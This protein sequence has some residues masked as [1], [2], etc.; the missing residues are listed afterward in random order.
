MSHSE[1]NEGGLGLELWR[2][3]WIGQLCVK[4]ELKA[5]FIFTLLAPNKNIST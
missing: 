4:N 5:T 1:V 2:E 3:M